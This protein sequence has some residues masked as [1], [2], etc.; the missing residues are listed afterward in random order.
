V[1]VMKLCA[2]HSNEYV[3]GVSN[4]H[5]PD[6]PGPCG[7]PGSGG[8]GP[9]PPA[10]CVHDVGADPLEKSTLWKLPPDG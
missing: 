5:V 3:P 8:T 2:S 10:V 4:R 7:P 1:P 9:L 6:Q